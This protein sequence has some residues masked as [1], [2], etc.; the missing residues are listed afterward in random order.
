MVT[1]NVL[2]KTFILFLS[3][4]SV[5]YYIYTIPRI[6]Y[7]PSFR[8]IISPILKTMFG[9]LLFLVVN[10]FALFTVVSI[11][12]CKPDGSDDCYIFPWRSWGSCT[13][14]CGHQK[15]NR[16]RFFCCKDNVIPHNLENCLEHCNFSN[17]FK[18]VH[19]RICRVCE[20][21]GTVLSAS[22]PC[23]CGSR[24][25]GDCC[26]GRNNYTGSLSFVGFIQIFA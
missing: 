7:Y 2:E 13:G 22:S 6:F 5:N 4:F 23:I 9:A 8:L 10:Y 3:L 1:I 26:E 24:Y 19:N 14:I 20:N 16:E 15:Q 17:A 21:G 11:E 25:K 12:Q 18:T